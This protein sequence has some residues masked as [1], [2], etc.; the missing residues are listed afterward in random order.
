MKKVFALP[1]IGLLTLFC[2]CQKQQTET[3]RNAEIERQ[4]NQR[5]AA[6]HQAEEQQQLAQRQAE[7][8]ARE[9]ALASRENATANTPEPKLRS[10][11]AY[12]IFPRL[13]RPPLIPRSTQGSSRWAFGARPP[14][15]VTSGN[16]ARPSNRAAGVPTPTAAGFTPTP[17]GPGFRKS[18]SAGRLITTDVGRACAVSAGS[19]CPVTNGRRRG[20]RGARAMITWVGR[21][22][23]PKRILIAAPAFRIGPTITTTSALNSIVLYQQENS[24]RSGP[25]G[26]WFQPNATSLSSMRRP[27]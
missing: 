12:A 5:L 22:F 19:G 18:R 14:P 4:V 20:F 6:E 15:T 7:L 21:R 25:S 8:D 26:L 17:V 10:R 11:A 2:S 9:K 13:R 27:T 16:R 24:E 23:L 1:A 3:E